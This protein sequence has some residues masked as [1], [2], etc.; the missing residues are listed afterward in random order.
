MKDSSSSANKN[1]IEKLES[2][3]CIIVL[4]INSQWLGHSPCATVA[5]CVV[6]LSVAFWELADVE[7]I[8]YK[9]HVQ[10]VF[11]IIVILSL[12]WNTRQNIILKFYLAFG[13]NFSKIVV[14]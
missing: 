14:I 1:W 12:G 11:F 2:S 6:L 10:N 3:E 7:H 9:I 5:P 8:L 4:W 13:Q